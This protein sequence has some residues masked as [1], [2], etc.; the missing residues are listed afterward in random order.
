MISAWWTSRSTMAATATASPKISVQ[1]E[2]GLFELT[3][4]EARS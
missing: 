3:I 4:M 2:N 1:A